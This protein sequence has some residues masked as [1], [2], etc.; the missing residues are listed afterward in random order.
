M[1]GKVCSVLWHT[2]IISIYANV[3]SRVSPVPLASSN[4]THNLTRQKYW[5]VSNRTPNAFSA[6]FSTV[7]FLLIIT[8]QQKQLPASQTDSKMTVKRREDRSALGSPF[9]KGKLFQQFMSRW[10]LRTHWWA[11]GHMPLAAREDEERGSSP[12]HLYKSRLVLST[13]IRGQME[14]GLNMSKNVKLNNIYIALYKH[15]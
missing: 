10:P 5:E 7:M 4:K 2:A 3:Y 1:D 11:L 8:R 9:I 12:F 15:R 13:G 6:F 14:E